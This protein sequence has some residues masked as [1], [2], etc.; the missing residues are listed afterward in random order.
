[1]SRFSLPGATGPRRA[2]R[3]AA[4]AVA[5]VAASL[6]LGACGDASDDSGGGGGTAAAD[7]G[8]A[9]GVTDDAITLASVSPLSGPSATTF[10]GFVE[11][12]EARFALQNADGGVNGREIT[13]EKNDDLGDGAAQ[14]T[15]ARNAVQQQQAFAIISASRVDTMF[16]F[17]ATQSVPVVGYPGQPAYV[18]D[19]N[20]FGFAGSG[21]IGYFAEAYVNKMV[22]L[23][24]TNLAVLAHNS[25][26]S[27]NS[28]NGMIQAAEA[29]DLEVGVKSLDVPLGSF[30]ATALAIQMKEAGADAIYAPT[31]T[32]SSVSVLRAAQQQGVDLKA[33]FVSSVYDPR[34]AD[35][36]SEF[37]Q[38]AITTTLAVV[39]NQLADENEA[40]QTYIDT[41]KEYAP[42]TDPSAGFAE[43]G[44]ISA[45]LFIKGVEEAGDCLTRESFIEGLRGVT[46]YDG[47][48]LLTEPAQFSG[49]D[50]PNGGQRYGSC[51]WFVTREGDEWVPDDEPTCGELIQIAG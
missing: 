11:A 25:P 34:V 38:G 36:I 44:Y 30:D 40:V 48:G 10:A 45:D 49:G 39:P 3:T 24:A 14:V 17:L 42:D 43:V 46:E 13:V 31:L 19:E 41:M 20:V 22:D 7:C 9:P 12:A 47:G 37:I 8:D 51:A 1:M 16:D 50:A 29:N 26:G 28:A 18:E 21:N 6:V 2:R 5:G 4:L 35:Q 15:A 32:D 23:G 27:L 33:V